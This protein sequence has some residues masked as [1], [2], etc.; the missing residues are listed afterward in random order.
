VP[1]PSPFVFD[2]PLSPD[3]VIDRQVEAD[4]LRAWGE[5]GRFVSL[6]AP[7]RYGKTS[8]LGKVAHEAWAQDETPVIIV[9]LYGLASMADLVVRLERAY[10]SH[11][12]G[13][14]RRAVE[15]VLRSTQLGFSLAGAGI[16]TRFA[17]RSSSDPLPALHAALDLPTRVAARYG[18]RCILVFDEFQAIMAVEGA[19]ALVRSHVQH[20]RGEASYIFAGS[21]SSLLD[22]VFADRARPFYGQAEPFR[23]GRL[24]DGPLAEAVESGFVRTDRGAGEALGALLELVEGHPQRAMLAAHCLWSATPV[25]T[26]ATQES[27]ESAL[28]DLRRRTRRE[29]EALWDRLGDADRR[30]LRAVVRYGSPYRKA[31]T[32]QL[33]LPRST[34]QSAVARLIRL[35]DLEESEHGLRFIDPALADWVNLRFPL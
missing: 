33:N 24:P 34:A 11:A 10:R 12:K 15:T 2:G 20:H 23:L 7:R 14:F 26:V 17:E 29:S 13:R 6:Y 19:E 21:E 28:D 16:S 22:A 9:D 4:E 3:E 25:G 31:A 8:L 5:A 18:R 30:T 35:G 32:T 1:G 27:W